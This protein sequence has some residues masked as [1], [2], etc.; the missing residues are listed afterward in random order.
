M[1]SGGQL[2]MSPDNFDWVESHPLHKGQTIH[3][4]GKFQTVRVPRPRAMTLKGLCLYLRISRSTWDQ[5][6]QAEGFSDIS[7]RARDV[8]WNWKF[9]LAAAD[10]LNASFIA[11]ELGLMDRKSADTEAVL[12]AD[13][14]VMA[15]MQ[16]MPILG[17]QSATASKGLATAAIP[18]KNRLRCRIRGPIRAGARA[19]ARE[20]SFTYFE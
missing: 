5:Y 20:K 8:I 19:C 9:E 6:A 4:A 2:C 10:L 12:S 1:P 11:R 18:G 17:S 16:S 13:N 3:H 15:L 14:S 7:M